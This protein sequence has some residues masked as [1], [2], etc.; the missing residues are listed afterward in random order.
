MKLSFDRAQWM[1]MGGESWLMLRTEARNAQKFCDDMKPGRVYD[2]ELKE[3]REKRSLD[4]NAYAWVLLG[5]LAAK[6]NIP[7][8][9][10]YRQIIRDVGDNYEILPIRDEA[11]DKWISAWEEKGIGWCC[12]VLG[13]SK[14]GGYTNVI[15]YYGSSTYDSKQMSNFISLIVQECGEQDIETATPRELSLLLEAVDG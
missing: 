1:L 14:L 7:K 9:E 12:D 13:K 10:V 4:A 2:A 15:A 3:H 11:V 5:K 8:E 6:L